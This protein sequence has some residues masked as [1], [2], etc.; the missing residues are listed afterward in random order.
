VKITGSMMS[1]TVTGTGADMIDWICV[2]ATN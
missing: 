2:P 1:V